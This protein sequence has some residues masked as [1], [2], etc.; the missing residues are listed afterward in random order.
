[1][2]SCQPAGTGPSVRS[3]WRGARAAKPLPTRARLRPGAPVEAVGTGGVGGGP[4]PAG[5]THSV[6]GEAAFLV[7]A[8]L[9]RG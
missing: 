8:S 9:R 5:L 4:G 1:M 3:E 6:C 7:V 2:V